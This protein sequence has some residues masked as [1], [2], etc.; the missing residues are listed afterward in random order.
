MKKRYIMVIVLIII[1]ALYWWSRPVPYEPISLA[2]DNVRG[3]GIEVVEFSDFE[4]PACQRAY[5]EV[6][7]A[8]SNASVKFTYK[9]FPLTQIHPRGLPAAEASECAADQ[10]KFWEYYDKLFQTRRLASE[11]FVSHAKA[12]SL[13][14]EKFK[15]CV[16]SGSMRSRVLADQQEGIARGVRATPTFFING[17]KYEGVLV[18]DKL[19]SLIGVK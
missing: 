13:D 15:I 3:E 5:P 12:L 1:V 11:D 8:F 17:K 7:E 9:H 10:G 19:R 6:E 4:C 14:V 18:A 2:G 16:K